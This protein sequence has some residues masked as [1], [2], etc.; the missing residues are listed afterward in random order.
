MS[1]PWIQFHCAV[2]NHPKTIKLCLELENE[3]AWAHLVRLWTW[4]ATNSPDGKLP[5][6]RVVEKLANW[7]GEPEKF[8]KAALKFGFLD[9]KKGEIFI[10]DWEEH[11]GAHLEELRRHREA[12]AR[13]RMKQKTF[14][15]ITVSSRESSRD[16]NVTALDRDRDR[17]KEEK[18][19]T[20]SP[21]KKP[22]A[23]AD[24]R[25]KPLQLRLEQVF[26]EVRGEKYSHGGPKDAVALKKLLAAWPDDEIVDTW[27][28]GLRRRDKWPGVSTVAQLSAKWNDLRAISKPAQ[29]GLTVAWD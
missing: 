3:E 5:D 29:E 22:P 18:K 26:F 23:V 14:G 4:C 27:E 11:A 2:L 25:F 15:D 8:L 6:P 21:A 19:R 7:K 24:P 17:D 13:W 20:A 1:L 12:S 28:F 10:H 9:E 16:S